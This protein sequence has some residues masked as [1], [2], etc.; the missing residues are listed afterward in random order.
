[1]G[2][3][4]VFGYKMAQQAHYGTNLMQNYFN[5][6]DATH[7][8]IQ[9]VQQGRTRLDAGLISRARNDVQRKSHDLDKSTYPFAEDLARYMFGDGTR[10]V[11]MFV[12]GVFHGKDDL[13]TVIP[14]DLGNN[15]HQLFQTPGVNSTID[16][17][18]TFEQTGEYLMRFKGTHGNE[19]AALGA[20]EF[21]VGKS[22]FF[23]FKQSDLETIFGRHLIKHQ[24]ITLEEMA[25]LAPLIIPSE[26]VMLTEV[27]APSQD[28]RTPMHVSYRLKHSLEEKL[29]NRL[30]REKYEDKRNVRLIADWVAHR[31]VLPTRGEVE[32]LEAF[33][34]TSPT[35][36]NSKIKYLYT[37]DY[38]KDEPKK[39][40]G[41][42]FKAK[43]VIVVVTTDHYE[44][45]LREI[46]IVDA[47]QYAK[48][49]LEKGAENHD[50]FKK[51][52]ANVPRKERAARKKI[53]GVLDQIFIK[54]NNFIPL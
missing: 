9:G 37:N 24:T 14:I 36:G 3:F 33:L 4:Y 21:E 52:R 50:D 48:N 47:E 13:A 44:P 54:T 20:Y 5:P 7:Q 39:G 38:Y 43:N 30:I 46:Q 8:V 35:I 40:S 2:L 32:V 11:I 34:R 41:R 25:L 42:Q 28:A 19:L 17:K 15:P 10:R 23:Y 45:A 22:R 27:K 12:E 16:Y 49:E 29:L 1:M 6:D 26:S 53:E 18:V 51:R 31:P